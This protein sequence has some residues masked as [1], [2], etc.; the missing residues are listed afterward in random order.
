MTWH[1]TGPLTGK[2]W[3]VLRS[4]REGACEAALA[5]RREHLMFHDFLCPIPIADI[6]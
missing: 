6:V 5:E 4:G 1:P 3:A 2:A